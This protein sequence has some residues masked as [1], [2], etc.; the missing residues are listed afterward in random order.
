MDL[1]RRRTRLETHAVAFQRLTIKIDVKPFGHFDFDPRQSGSHEH[2][3]DAETVAQQVLQCTDK[4]LGRRQNADIQQSI[5]GQRLWAQHMP[6]SGLT[7]IADAQRQQ[8]AAPVKIRALQL[9]VSGMQFA[10]S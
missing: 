3:V 5:V 10:E 4:L 7:A 9:A 8:L 2:V 1:Q 6:A